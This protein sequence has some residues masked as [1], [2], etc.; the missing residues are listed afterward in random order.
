MAVSEDELARL[1]ERCAITDGN[2]ITPGDVM[3]LLDLA[4]RYRGER[5]SAREFVI[6]L[7]AFVRDEVA[8]IATAEP[9]G[10]AGPDLQIYAR[11]VLARVWRFDRDGW[12][13]Q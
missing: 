13:E 2:G 5:D 9:E 3:E 4:R 10:V 11:E 7:L 6:D 8:R 12:D 1:E